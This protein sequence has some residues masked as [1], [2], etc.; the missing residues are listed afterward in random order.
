MI[1]MN[2]GIWYMW[3]LENILKKRLR[4]NIYDWFE[5]EVMIW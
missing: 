1:L 5:N 3:I 2:L 4:I